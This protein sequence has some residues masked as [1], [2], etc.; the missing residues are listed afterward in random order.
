MPRLKSWPETLFAE[1]WT[2]VDDSN[3]EAAAKV[4]DGSYAWLEEG[5][6]DPAGDGPMIPEEVKESAAAVAG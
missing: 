4:L 5:L 1:L 6:A 2:N 3:R